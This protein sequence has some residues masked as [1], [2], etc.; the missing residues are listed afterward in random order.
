MLLAIVNKNLL[1]ILRSLLQ[2]LVWFALYILVLSVVDPQN[3]VL[4][5]LPQYFTVV[6]VVV[7]VV[8]VFQNDSSRIFFFNF[9]TQYQSHF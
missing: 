8:V 9:K 7:V 1:R 5:F 6:V 2:T 4:L 3:H